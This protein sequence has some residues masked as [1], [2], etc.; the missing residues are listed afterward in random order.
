MCLQ[1]LASR[2]TCNLDKGRRDVPRWWKLSRSWR[3]LRVQLP[4]TGWDKGKRVVVVG[5]RQTNPRS[6]LEQHRPIQDSL[7]IHVRYIRH[8]RMNT[9]LGKL[10][11]WTSLYQWKAQGFLVLYSFHAK[12]RTEPSRCSMMRFGWTENN[13][14]SWLNS[15]HKF[16]LCKEINNLSYIQ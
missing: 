10:F 6:K 11:F 7:L 16:W 13:V 3:S 8:R 2:C 14:L 5:L 1:H 4:V 9:E 12:R 15:K